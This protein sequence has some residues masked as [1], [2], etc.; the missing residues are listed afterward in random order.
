LNSGRVAISAGGRFQLITPPHEF[1]V[2]TSM[3]ERERAT[4][5][6]W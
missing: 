1:V 6:W 5:F 2:T 3:P 4:Q